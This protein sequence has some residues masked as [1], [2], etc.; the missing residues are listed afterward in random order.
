[1]RLCA[2]L[3]ASAIV[4]I[5]DIFV[6]T[7]VFH[8]LI[9]VMVLGI[10]FFPVHTIKFESDKLDNIG[11]IYGMAGIF[12]VGTG[13]YIGGGES[14]HAYIYITF[15]SALFVLILFV[16]INQYI[17]RRGHST[18]I[19]ICSISLITASFFFYIYYIIASFIYY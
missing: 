4:K 12:L 17:K 7:F 16:L 15:L 18:L 13:M 11:A 5:G 1:M 6:V 10:S 9:S 19:N 8:I 14:L 3:L 2:D